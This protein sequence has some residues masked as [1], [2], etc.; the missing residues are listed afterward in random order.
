MLEHIEKAGIW[1]P[2][3]EIYKHYRSIKAKLGKRMN[4][5]NAAR[6]ETTDKTLKKPRKQAIEELTMM[7]VY[8][9]RFQL[10]VYFKA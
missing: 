7:L 8:L 2:D 1:I 6:K 4:R 3:G 5:E 10:P 9:T